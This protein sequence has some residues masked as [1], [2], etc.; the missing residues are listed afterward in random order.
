MLGT[1]QLNNA[2]EAWVMLFKAALDL[3]GEWQHSKHYPEAF[4]TD[5][6]RRTGSFLHR[7]S[8]S[9]ER[10]RYDRENHAWMR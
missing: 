5:L 6:G 3:S 1:L 4:L 9:A 2:S 8:V 7:Q 10:K